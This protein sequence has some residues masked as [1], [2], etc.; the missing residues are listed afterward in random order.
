MAGG[1]R[2]R[3][4]EGR[5]GSKPR[6]EDPGAAALADLAARQ[7]LLESDRAGSALTAQLGPR[8]DGA[9]PNAGGEAD[10]HGPLRVQPLQRAAHEGPAT[11]VAELPLVLVRAHAVMAQVRVGELA[12]RAAADQAADEIVLDGLPRVGAEQRERR[13]PRHRPDGDPQIRAAVGAEDTT[14][15]GERP[16]VA[17]GGGHVDL[18]SGSGRSFGGHVPTRSQG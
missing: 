14:G 18:L 2:P 9:L 3:G 4:G 13:A 12:E 1:W 17:L 16:R 6:L 10:L 8:Q 7:D 15:Q 11:V 5:R